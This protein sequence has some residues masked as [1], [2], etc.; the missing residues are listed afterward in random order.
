[1]P[2]I[3]P[4]VPGAVFPLEEG[5]CSW[6]LDLS[7]VA[8]W[9][10]FPP[11]VQS[12]AQAWSTYI[13]WALTGRRYGPCSITVRPCG[14]RCLGLSGYLTFP[15]ALGT[16]SGSGAP[17]MIPWIDNGL[18]RNCGCTGGCTCSA[19]CEIALPGPVAVID[20]VQVD[21]VILPSSSYRLDMMKGIP[22]LV[23]TDGEC[24]P[25]CQ[26][27][28]ADVGEPGSFAITY[29]RGTPVPRAGQIAAGILAGEFAKNCQGADCQLPQQ[30]ASLSRNGVEVTV[31]DPASLLEN[32]LTGIAQVD[33]WIRS[34]NPTRKAQ[35]SRVYSPDMMGPRFAT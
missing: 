8:D 13:L 32:G 10:S 9:A 30:L 19:T 11:A 14:P 28:D 27:M 18:W 24:W 5:P 21:G 6:P 25:D 2:A 22:V 20:E 29:Q 17:W 12:A 33:L 31:V 7:C 26:D 35:R 34:V 23:R 3:N 15:V 1:M 4:V 16:T